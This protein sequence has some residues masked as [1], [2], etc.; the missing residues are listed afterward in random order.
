MRQSEGYSP[1]ICP[2]CYEQTGIETDIGWY[3]CQWCWREWSETRQVFAR[4]RH[5]M[6]RLSWT[7]LV[8]GI[9]L[10]FLWGAAFLLW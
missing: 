10:L 3:E 2:S 8:L 9:A 4:L 5:D 7:Y 6:Q 1:P